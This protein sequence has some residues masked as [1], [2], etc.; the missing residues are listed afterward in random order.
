MT[1]AAV[2]TGDVIAALVIT[3]SPNEMAGATDYTA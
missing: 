1:A 3:F 2:A